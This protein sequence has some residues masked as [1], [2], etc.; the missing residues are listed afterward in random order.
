MT[1]YNQL[2]GLNVFL[3]FLILLGSFSNCV[4]F[5]NMAGKL[6]TNIWNSWIILNIVQK[7]KFDYKTLANLTNLYDLIINSCGYDHIFSLLWKTKMTT[8]ELSEVNV[9]FLFFAWRALNFIYLLSKEYHYIIE[10]LK[11][12][13]KL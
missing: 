8:H 7:F 6:F 3:R 4:S 11:I 1:N 2:R 12:C 10:K 9:M 5:S 13:F